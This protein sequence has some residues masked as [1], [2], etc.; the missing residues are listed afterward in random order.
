MLKMHLKTHFLYL[1]WLQII[2]INSMQTMIKLESWKLQ[3]W[4]TIYKTRLAETYI[5]TAFLLYKIKNRQNQALLK[6][7]IMKS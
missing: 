2:G 4:L 7:Y 3:R 5:Q 6:H 1:F